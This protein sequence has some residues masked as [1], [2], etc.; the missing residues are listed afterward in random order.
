MRALTRALLRTCA[1]GRSVVQSACPPRVLPPPPHE[2]RRLIPARQVEAGRHAA[3]CLLPVPLRGRLWLAHIPCARRRLHPCHCAADGGTAVRRL[4][5][6]QQ[7]LAQLPDGGRQATP[8]SAA[9]DPTRTGVLLAA[10]RCAL[11][12]PAHVAAAWRLG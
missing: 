3:G 11:L 12:T 4:A 9:R 10:G 1:R 8:G 7:L 6:V 5:A 2:P